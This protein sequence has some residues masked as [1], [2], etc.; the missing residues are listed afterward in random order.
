[1]TETKPNDQ[2]PFETLIR[3]FNPHDV[4][5]R[6]LPERPSRSQVRILRTLCEALEEKDWDKACKLRERTLAAFGE[7][8]RPYHT[9][10]C[11]IAQMPGFAQEVAQG[12]ATIGARLAEHLSEAILKKDPPEDSAWRLN[13][14]ERL[15]KAYSLALA[16]MVIASNEKEPEPSFAKTADWLD[17]IAADID[18]T[19]WTHT[20]CLG[21]EKGHQ[22]ALN[23]LKREEAEKARQAATTRVELPQEPPFVA[24]SA[25]QTEDIQKEGSDTPETQNS[26]AA[27]EH[28]GEPKGVMVIS[29]VGSTAT[30]VGKEAK[31]SVN[32]IIGKHVPE[33]EASADQL[34]EVNRKLTQEFPYAVDLIDRLM[35]DL[36]PDRPV[37]FQPTA[38]VGEP[39]G[40]KSRLARRLLEELNL[41]WMR[42]DAGSTADHALT[43]TARRWSTGHPSMPLSLIEAANLANPAMIVDE[44]EKAGRSNS[45]SIHDALLS[46]LERSTAAA[47]HDPYVDTHINVS[48]ISWLFTCNGLDGVPA[49]L[50]NRL[51]VM[52]MPRPK[53]EHIPALATQIMRELLKEKGIEA[54]WEPPLD[55]VEIDVLTNAC[56]QEFSMRDLQRFVSALLEARKVTATRN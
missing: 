33:R 37:W 1:M 29:A 9:Y 16:W 45:G 39:G 15:R 32:T 41:P 11:A 4:L 42:L 14:T 54:P 26:G 49:P 48:H 13:T 20:F 8:R 36:V 31:R 24:T 21:V 43:G 7:A 51:R 47:W 55:P 46:L 30:S 6:D 22:D 56:G 18:T 50:K 38:L 3:H 10:A 52:V 35:S 53:R 44:I 28:A 40:G 19:L 17:E 34:T 25:I 27:T 23:T 2:H 5:T 12:Y